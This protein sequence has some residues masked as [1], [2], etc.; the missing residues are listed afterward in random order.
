[1]QGLFKEEFLQYIWRTK[2]FNLKN[3]QTTNNKTIDIISFGV[4]NQK[5][6]PDFFG[7]KVIIDGI[8]WV[9]SIEIHVKSS[10]WKLHKHD[11]DPNYLNVILHVVYEHDQEISLPNG[12]I[13]PCLELKNRIDPEIIDKYVFL[14]NQKSWIS[15]A[16][17]LH[18]VPE[19]YISNAKARS[20]TSRLEGRSLKIV[21]ELSDVNN[22]LQQLIFKRFFWSFGLKSNE[23]AFITL[24]DSIPFY[25][26]KK[27]SRSITHLEALL[28]G[29][30]G[31]LPVVD[32]EGYIELLKKEYQ[33]LKLKYSLK[34]MSIVWWNFGMVRPSGFPTIRI[35]QLAQLLNK[36]P[37]LDNLIFEPNLNEILNILDIQ[38]S[39]YWE[40]HFH[41]GKSSVRKIKRLGRNKIASIVINVIVPILF[42]LGHIRYKEEFKSRAIDFLENLESEQNNIINGWKRIKVKSY[43]AYDSQA[44]IHQKIDF[45]NKFQCL[46][47][48]IGHKILS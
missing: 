17:V 6:G 4:L 34:P 25:L 29:Q 27:Y 36:I 38:I 37:R 35:A 14:K 47:C 23:E 24:F 7:S 30:S 5:G 1:M 19:F 20:L 40:N 31:L 43:S 42:T 2:R 26:I 3:L 46:K 11:A 39:G 16:N 8:L 13:I 9:G 12:T 44:L 28:F 22:D 48:P 33:F 45:C 15:C 10:V 41:F 21:Q 18:S 32:K